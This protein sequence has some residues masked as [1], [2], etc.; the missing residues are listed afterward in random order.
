MTA[1]V[2][3]IS[4]N[5]VAPAVVGRP[6]GRRVHAAVGQPAVQPL[7]ADPEPVFRAVV[8]ARR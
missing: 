7:A 4:S 2:A 8:R 5:T 1:P 3:I 6:V